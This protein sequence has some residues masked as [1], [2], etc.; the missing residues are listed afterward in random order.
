M[1][2]KGK[3]RMPKVGETVQYYPIQDD[4]KSMQMHKNCNEAHVLPAIVTAVWSEDCVNLKVI[5]DG[6]KPDMW[7]TSS[8]KATND[9]NGGQWN[10]PE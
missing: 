1:F 9:E 3:E 5:F 7:V 8:T 10:Y 4:V 6:E 2:G